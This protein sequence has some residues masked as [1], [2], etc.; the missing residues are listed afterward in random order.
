M[1]FDDPQMYNRK[2]TVRIP[3]ELV[4]DNDIFEMFCQQNE[5]DRP[6]MVK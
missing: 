1:T 6:H 4:P 2:F 3:H 5:K